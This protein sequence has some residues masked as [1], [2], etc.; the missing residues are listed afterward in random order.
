MKI[1]RGHVN[2]FA[3]INDTEKQVNNLIH[4]LHSSLTPF[5]FY[6]VKALIIDENLKKDVNWAFHPMENNAVVEFKQSEFQKFLDAAGRT[7]VFVKLD[8]S[9]EEEKALA[10]LSKKS[11]VEDESGKTKLGIDV[12]KEVDI[13]EWY[14]QVITKSE[15]IEY[16]DI[17]GCYILRPNS[18]S[19]WESIQVRNKTI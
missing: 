12:K 14:R 6:Q 15:L 8:I 17:S 9:E 1:K 4:S 11:K 5:P 2:P 10:E 16:Y 19:I 3:L 18:Y 7:A 13:S